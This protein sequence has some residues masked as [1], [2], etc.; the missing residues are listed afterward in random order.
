[1]TRAR[2]S[3][4]SESERGRTVKTT[5]KR[6]DRIY[7]YVDS[8]HIAQKRK[9]EQGDDNGDLIG[10]TTQMELAGVA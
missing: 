8:K 7:K 9:R 10:F 3:I 4:C 2:V 1:M 6:P 5:E